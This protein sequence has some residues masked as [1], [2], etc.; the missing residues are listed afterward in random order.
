[1]RAL[2]DGAHVV[3]HDLEWPI[4]GV[5]VLNRIVTTLHGGAVA[6]MPTRPV[7]DSV[8]AV[9]PGGVVTRTLDRTRLRAVH[10][11][12]GF[13]AEVLARLVERSG[14]GSF[15]ELEAALSAGTPVTFV[16]GDDEALSVEL[17]RDSD[18]LAALIEGRQDVTDR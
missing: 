16:E 3:V 14:S 5:G 17:P 11:P 15:D 8:K 6:V 4:V 2:A 7:T 13:D 10:Y 1:L 18:Y 12:R 9:G